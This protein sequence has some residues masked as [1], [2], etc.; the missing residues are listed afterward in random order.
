MKTWQPSRLQWAV[1]WG[2]FLVASHVW[3][4][5]RLSHF[6]P[7]S[8]GAWGLPGYLQP[9][10]H[11]RERSHFALVIVVMGLLL[12]WQLRGRGSPH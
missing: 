7:D 3:L 9:A 6:L 11:P 5:L 4:G 8:T 10:L 12:L 2:T 1:I